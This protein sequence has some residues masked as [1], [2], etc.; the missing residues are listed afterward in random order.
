VVAEAGKYEDRALR[1]LLIVEWNVLDSF[2]LGADLL[3]VPFVPVERASLGT[4]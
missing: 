4:L 1:Q 2:D 3:P